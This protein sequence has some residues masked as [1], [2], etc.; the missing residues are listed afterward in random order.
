MPLLLYYKSTITPATDNKKHE[1]LV[2]ESDDS[3]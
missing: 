2:G 3:Y 1:R